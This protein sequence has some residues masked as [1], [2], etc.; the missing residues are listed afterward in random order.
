MESFDRY[1]PS[2]AVLT[3]CIITVNAH[4][5]IF[6]VT[7][8]S[9]SGDGSLRE[10][11]MDANTT[12]A[13]D[14]I[15]FSIPGSGPH[16]IALSS[17]LPAIYHPVFINGYSQ[18]DAEP[19]SATIPATILVEISYTGLSSFT[20]LRLQ[21]ESC[22][23]QGLAVTGFDT[24]ISVDE[25]MG[26]H[27]TG[28]YIGVD[29]SGQTVHGNTVGIVIQAPGNQIGGSDP[30]ARNVI[31]G[32]LEDGIHILTGNWTDEPGPGT[33]ITGNYI[34]VDATGANDRGNG[35]R[36]IYIERSADNSIGGLSTYEQNIIA[37]NGTEGVFVSHGVR[38]A[39]RGNAI[40][41]NGSLGIDLLWDYWDTEPDGIN[42]N[43][44]GD[45]DW[46]ANDLQNFPVLT[47]VSVD[48][49]STTV[50]GTLNSTGDSDFSIDIFLNASTDFTTYGEGER[51]F[52]TQIVHTNDQGDVSFSVVIPQEITDGEFISATATDESGNTSEFSRCIVFQ[53]SMIVSNCDDTGPGS[54]RNALTSANLNPGIDTI[55]FDLQGQG[56]H[57]I[58]PSFTLP[59][60]SDPVILDGYSQE[61]AVPADMDT[62]ALLQVQIHGG[63]A[64]PDA[65]G[66]V[67]LSG[68]SIVRGLCI[69]GF[70]GYGLIIDQEGDNL[71]EGNF[72]GTTMDGSTESA[73][74][75]GIGIGYT[76]G[77]TV[78]GLVPSARNIISGNTHEGLAI[79]GDENLVIGN[80]IGLNPAGTQ[81]I[82]NGTGIIVADNNTIGGN[83]TGASNIISG[84]NGDGIALFGHDNS[85]V[86]NYI[87]DPSP[88]FT[89]LGNG[90][91][92]IRVGGISTV[93]ASA[94]GF[95]RII[96]EQ[97]L[98]EEFKAPPIPVRN[99]LRKNII[100]GNGELGIDIDPPGVNENDA[101][102]GDDGVNMRQ[103]FP[104]I[105]NVTVSA[106]SL[107]ILGS[108]DSQPDTQYHIDLYLNLSPDASAHGEGQIYLGSTTVTTD[109]DGDALFFHRY[110]G[111]IPST[112]FI[113]G[114]ATDSEN[115]TSEF[116]R[117][118]TIG[119]DATV[120]N[121]NDQGPGSLRQAILTT[122]AS[123]LVSEITFEIPG[124]GPH[125][126][127]LQD[128][129]P[130]LISPTTINGYSQAGSQMTT[131]S[132]A[133]DLRIILDGS[134]V[135]SGS[136]GIR[137]ESDGCTIKGVY[138]ASF[139][140]S[141][142]YIEDAEGITVEGNI[143]GVPTNGD[144]YAGN[145]VGITVNNGSD[146]TIGG[147]TSGAR[148]VISG[149]ED[150]GIRLDGEFAANNLIMGNYVGVSES[151]TGSVSNGTSGILLNGP[152]N[153]VGGAQ[154]GA[155]NIISG[156][157]EHGIQIDQSTAPGNVI[158]GNYIGTDSHGEVVVANGNCGIWLRTPENRI[159][160]SESEANIISGNTT[161]GICLAYVSAR[162]N[163]IRN[164]YIGTN[165]SGS[166]ALGNSG[167]G[168]W[169][170]G[171]S[172]NTIGG[173]TVGNTVAFNS[174]AG[175]EIQSGARNLLSQNKVYE[176]TGLGIDLN[177][178][179]VTPNDDNDSDSG[180]NGR[181][182]FPELTG[183]EFDSVSVLAVSGTLHSA[184][185]ASYTLQFF[186]SATADE[187]GYGE[188][189]LYVG[190]IT[191]STDGNGDVTFKE[192]LEVGFISGI[193]VIAATA[194]DDDN[195]TSEFS[196]VIPVE[197]LA[198]DGSTP[199]P[200]EQILSWSPNPV[201][202]MTRVRLRLREPTFATVRIYNM[203]GER[204]RTVL[205]DVLTPGIHT[206]AWDTTD[207]DGNRVSAG[208]YLYRVT[209]KGIDRSGKLVL[210][211]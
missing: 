198:V 108:L 188:G 114:T 209:G 197:G 186:L 25:G 168:I 193:Y 142:I 151:G 123:D 82:G 43:D 133:A 46:G 164:N 163:I 7:T 92:G 80:I 51:Y 116:G 192:Q 121:T 90:G 190:E 124:D 134:Q 58:Y 1:R 106:D 211:R 70:A 166:V 140:G 155:R 137:I 150:E 62:P 144:L 148:N 56:P 21:A 162:D 127:T 32:N 122:N 95:G 31:S 35:L 11:I 83:E 175:I 49:G 79:Y 195:N 26:T 33:V 126:I 17:S 63:N 135:S 125:V 152:D 87:G 157:G 34:G 161:A 2:L 76:E 119:G 48:E 139:P 180:A 130:A 57:I 159:G 74:G 66:I 172:D 202:S 44:L 156:N 53:G 158:I 167:P 117:C 19:A 181:Q 206:I 39:I 178:E 15:T 191:V 97:A 5:E 169:I 105:D 103:N 170:R 143:L 203:S 91:T 184:P 72:I 86:N 141:A 85:I 52:G 37:Y 38:N 93:N 111:D 100:A 165:S 24:G 9:T 204:I 183:A 207:D 47:G 131:D 23:V 77:N 194:I 67:I 118:F 45:G 174:G 55:E 102:D 75:R 128:H 4:A 8:T 129:L 59:F 81:S 20:G 110:G 18:P 16:Q 208:T 146:N 173:Q 101:G 199:L 187:S 120:T 14:T 88:E 30:S 210:I 196:L 3:A 69:S 60:I 27:I 12:A 68:G 78:G 13:P 171:S 42:P 104:V 36:G 40:Y 94:Y 65:H 154:Q 29:H 107:T 182:N 132:D 147:F 54:L 71:I 149:N 50:N 73:N 160:G 201:S 61:G 99:E 84:N 138:I 113:S 189:E 177:P 112:G 185:Q 109:A 153:I 96:G 98:H 145:G 89:N 28:N 115:N 41:A 200:C 179:G 176:N 205:N 10:A 64:G 22:R 6:T 136:D